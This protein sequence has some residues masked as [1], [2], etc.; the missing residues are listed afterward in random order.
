MRQVHIAEFKGA[1][2]VPRDWIVDDRG[3]LCEI[4]ANS[5]NDEQYR[6]EHTYITTCDPNVVKAWH[7]HKEQI[8]KFFCIRGKLMVIVI[9]EKKE[10][11][12]K[13]VLT[14]SNPRLL[15]IE[16]NI[17]HG[18]TAIGGEEAWVLN[19][20]TKSYNHDEPDEYRRPFNAFLG[21]TI[22]TPDS[23]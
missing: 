17:Y 20:P 15:I 11:Y 21:E 16:K 22:W 8:D 9:D 14:P 1:F 3:Q 4:F 7:Y 12:S 10:Q 6:T 5:N 19:L 23:K 2:T 18:F 13:V